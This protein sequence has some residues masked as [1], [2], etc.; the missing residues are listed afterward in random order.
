MKFR[1]HPGQKCEIPGFYWQHNADGSIET[2]PEVVNEV[3]GPTKE[4]GGYY[5]LAQ[6]PEMF[7][8]HRYLLT[9]A[10]A[11]VGMYLKAEETIPKFA[12]EP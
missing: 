9:S 2:Y 10:C 1:Y 8:E 12:P 5:T 11:K 4:E 6:S 7:V 3:F